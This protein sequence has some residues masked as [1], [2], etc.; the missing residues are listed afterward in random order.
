MPKQRVTRKTRGA[1]LIIALS[2]LALFSTLGMLYVR[3]TN[4][5]LEKATLTLRLARAESLAIAGVNAA[6]GDLEHARKARQLIQ[7]L[8][9]P[10]TYAFNTYKGVRTEDG[11]AVDTMDNRRA[12]ARVTIDDESGKVNLNH[13]PPKVLAEILGID[14]IT[15]RKINF[16]LPNAM[17][18]LLRKKGEPRRWLV[19]VDD[20][21][22]LGHLTD[23][24]FAAVDKSAI[25]T[26]S[27]LDHSRPEGYLNLNTAPAKV[28]A[29]V[30]GLSM[31]EAEELATHRPFKSL[32]AVSTFCGRAPAEFNLRMAPDGSPSPAFSL[33]SRCF[34]I[35]SDASYAGVDD[36]GG[37]FRRAIARVKALVLFDEDGGYRIVHWDALRGAA[38]T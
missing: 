8:G 5:G 6:I 13:A 17:L 14:I 36:G 3:H 35:I 34:Q 23:Q 24:Q 16:S 21:V 30:L 2:M 7:V 26:Y 29:A 25:T 18:K 27:V 28:L 33:G 32:E 38:A 37:E 31:Q 11:L 10:R 22:T 9:K 20:L 1:A 4:I 12:A 19:G 15:A